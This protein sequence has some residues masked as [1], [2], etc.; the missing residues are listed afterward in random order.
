[1]L[2]CAPSLSLSFS[3]SEE[4]ENCH[5]KSGA[6]AKPPVKSPTHETSAVD[7]REGRKEGKT[8]GKEKKDAINSRY[9]N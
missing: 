6:F 5:K 8:V 7:V 3:L 9:E 2:R 1:M 4:K